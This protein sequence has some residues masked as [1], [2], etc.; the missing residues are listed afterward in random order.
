MENTAV[1][2]NELNLHMSTWMN[3]INIISETTKFQK[4]I[5]ICNHSYIF[6]NEHICIHVEKIRKPGLQRKQIHDGDCL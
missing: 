6:R 3:I 4:S 1:K 5:Y 2:I